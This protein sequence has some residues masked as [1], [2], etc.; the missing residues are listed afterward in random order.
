MTGSDPD[1]YDR[2]DQ[3]VKMHQLKFRK[4]QGRF[5]VCRLHAGDTFPDGAAAGPLFSFTRT[6]HEVSVVCPEAI[7]PDGVR[8]ELAWVAFELQGPFPF[9]QTGILASFIEPLAEA[10]IPIFTISTFDTDYVLV[11]EGLLKPALDALCAAG[12]QFL[13]D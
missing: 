6:A 4:L 2:T 10:E 3:R 13:G 1:S 8:A 11:K 9:S 12:H 5:A 7:V